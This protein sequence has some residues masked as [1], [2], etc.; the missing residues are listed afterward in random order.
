MTAEALE[1]SVVTGNPQPQRLRVMSEAP[2]TGSIVSGVVR[3]G[4]SC[5]SLYRG[6][7]SLSANGL[8]LRAEAFRVAVV[9]ALA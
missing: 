1:S 6:F 3:L 2:Q 9:A 7:R 5:I 4:S 8:C